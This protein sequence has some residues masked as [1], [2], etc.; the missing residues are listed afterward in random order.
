MVDINADGW[1]D[2]YVCQVALLKGV[3][4]KNLLYIDQESSTKEGIPTFIENAAVYGLDFAGYS[5]QSAFFDY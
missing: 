3:K 4:G 5:T 2:I 1:L